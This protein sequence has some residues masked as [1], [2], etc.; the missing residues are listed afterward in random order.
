MSPLRSV[1]R[2][3][4]LGP[5]GAGKSTLA[6]R[7]APALGLPLIHLD[8][9]Y[10]Q[11]GW[12]VPEPATW[13]RHHQ[14]LVERPRWLIEGNYGSTI[15][16]R[17]ARADFVILLDYPRRLYLTRVLFRILRNWGRTRPDMGP[18]CPEQLDL[19]F[20]RYVWRYR[21]DSKPVVERAL[22][23]HPEVPVLRLRGPRQADRLLACLA[24]VH[25][26]RTALHSVSRGE[27]SV[28]KPTLASGRP[29]S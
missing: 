20:L 3:L 10:W 24:A 11:P 27:A 17:L 13:Q 22:R 21:R 19:E 12:T 26:M 14:T 1:R 23:R 4:V 18:G 16:P 6:R 15:D 28:R 2:L 7:L 25:G 5:C 8:R 9:E 29:L